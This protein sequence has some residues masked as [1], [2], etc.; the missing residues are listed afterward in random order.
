[1][2]LALRR[3]QTSDLFGAYLGY[4][5]V[6]GTEDELFPLKPIRNCA[7]EKDCSTRFNLGEAAYNATKNRST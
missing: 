4:L 7:N 6:D 3:L 2:R 5:F 1:M